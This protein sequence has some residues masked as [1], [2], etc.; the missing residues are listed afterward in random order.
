MMQWGRK[1]CQPNQYIR[2]FLFHTA[3]PSGAGRPFCDNED[4]DASRRPPALLA[5]RRGLGVVEVPVGVVD[6][7]TGVAGFSPILGLLALEVALDARKV[8]LT[9]TDLKV[10]GFL[11]E[12]VLE[13]PLSSFFLD[14]SVSE[15][16]LMLTSAE[17]TTS[18]TI[19]LTSLS[20]IATEESPFKTTSGHAGASWVGFVEASRL[21]SSVCIAKRKKNKRSDC[22]T[23]NKCINQTDQENLRAKQ[24]EPQVL[25]RTGLA[26]VP[27]PSSDCSRRE[28]PFE[29]ENVTRC[30]RVSLASS[31]L[32]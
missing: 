27:P 28:I 24:Q 8:L 23:T 32:E 14:V 29:G 22:D 31:R 19:S 7:G 15:P 3:F 6:V 20:T 12:E 25:R 18:S 5:T 1:Q 4:L 13:W 2:R 21:P 26:W 30:F 17:L 11:V 16:P 10:A 9:E